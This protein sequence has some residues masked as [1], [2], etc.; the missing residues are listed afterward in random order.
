M[1]PITQRTSFVFAPNRRLSWL[2]R[3]PE[4][5]RPLPTKLGPAG[6]RSLLGVPSVILSFFDIDRG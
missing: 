2:A 1:G 5:T 3:P 6:G 4:M